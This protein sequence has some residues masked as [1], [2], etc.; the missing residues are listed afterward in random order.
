VTIRVAASPRFVTAQLADVGIGGTDI[1]NSGGSRELIDQVEALNRRIEIDSRAC[2][3]THIFV[4]LPEGPA[5]ML[6][7][8]AEGTAADP[9][10][11][12]RNHGR[13]K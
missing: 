6:A 12:T 3:G 5:P 7:L 4:E 13:S 9:P 8:V 1:A 11:E 2:G 10:A